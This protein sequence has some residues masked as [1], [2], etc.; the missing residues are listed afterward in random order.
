MYISRQPVSPI[1]NMVSAPIAPSD[2]LDVLEPFGTTVAVRRG[3]EIYKRDEP[4]RFCWRILSGCARTVHLMDDGRRQ[5]SEFLWPG[6]M[7][8]MNDPEAYYEDAE[9]VTELT[10]RRYARQNVEAYANN[11]IAFALLLRTMTLENLRFA[12]RQI[13]LLGRKTAVE[14]IA[15]FLLEMDRQS[16][17]SGARLVE[18]PMNRTDIA[19]HLGLSIET[20]CRNLVSLQREG[21]VA[22]RRSGVELLDRAALLELACEAQR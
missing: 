14:R 9:A 7:I 3:H 19:D 1:S 18:L 20:V 5:I 22:L 11:H 10:L 15:S 6:G 21:M 4:A 2:A 12:H 17:T 8:G 13:A 16:A